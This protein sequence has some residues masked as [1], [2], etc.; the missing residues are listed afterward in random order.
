MRT[1]GIARWNVADEQL[2]S[3]MASARL[4]VPGSPFGPARRA[5]ISASIFSAMLAWLAQTKSKNAQ[6]SKGGLLCPC[7]GVF[8]MRLLERKAQD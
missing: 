8:M 3:F 4:S 6:K 1:M 5:W 2:A 7:P